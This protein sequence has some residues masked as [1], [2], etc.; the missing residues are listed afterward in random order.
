MGMSFTLKQN[1]RMGATYFYKKAQ[2][3]FLETKSGF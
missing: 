3:R 2:N 1:A